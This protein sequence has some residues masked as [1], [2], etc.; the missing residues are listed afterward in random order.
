MDIFSLVYPFSFLSPSL[1]EKA[2]YRLTYC[3]KGPLSPKQ[4]INQPTPLCFLSHFV[5][6]IENKKVNK[7]FNVL[8]IQS[9]FVISKSKGPSG[10][11]RVIRNSTY[12]M[13]RIEEN[14]N[15]TAKFHKLT[16][17]LTPL[18]SGRVAQSVGVLGSIP[19]LA[20]YFRFSFPFFKKGS[21][22]LLAKICAR[23]TG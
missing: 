2:R 17:N 16:C 22:Q 15:R 1:W 13:C 3:L 4:P 7:K 6:K 10:T 12:M 18:V 23:S 5:L 11:L 21:F 20:T 14:T 9:T 19:G 8:H